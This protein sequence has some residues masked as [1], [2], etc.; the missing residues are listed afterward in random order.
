MAESKATP[1]QPEIKSLQDRID[2]WRES[3][4][5]GP[6]M[7]MELW[8]EAANLATR[9]GVHAVARDLKLG[10]TRLKKFTAEKTGKPKVGNSET[11]GFV[12]LTQLPAAIQQE[13][14]VTEVEITRADGA[15][16]VIRQ[17]EAGKMD[18][19]GLV[20]GFCQGGK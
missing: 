9:Y 8:D 11:N 6:R 2:V 1:I 15:K 12:E 19:F 16:I 13:T 3:P 17:R 14:W 18:M 10:Y 4:D 20:N 5:K 7:P